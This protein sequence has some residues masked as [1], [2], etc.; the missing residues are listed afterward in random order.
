MMRCL[1]DRKRPLADAT[2]AAA[3]SSDTSLVC[4]P[5]AVLCCGNRAAARGVQGPTCA[6]AGSS[7]GGGDGG[8]PPNAPA[9]AGRHGAQF[10]SA[11]LRQDREQAALRSHPCTDTAA[12]S[13]RGAPS[14]RLCLWHGHIRM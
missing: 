8:G 12:P 10:L 3:A 11:A 7:S 1:M 13:G 4:T 14:L 9:Q 6:A 5:Q 2:L